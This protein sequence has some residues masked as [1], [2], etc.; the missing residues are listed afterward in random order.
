MMH[1]E[2]FGFYGVFVKVIVAHE[3]CVA[4]FDQFKRSPSLSEGST[5][6]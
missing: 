4:F 2:L 5:D 6:N 1:W 3:T